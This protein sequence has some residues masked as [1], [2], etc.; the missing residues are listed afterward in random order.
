M[1][2]T[3]NDFVRTVTMSHQLT[4]E[5]AKLLD[6]G[7]SP[8]DLRGT[9]WAQLCPL[10]E[11]YRFT[12]LRFEFVPS[13]PSVVGGQAISY[14]EL[15][16]NEEFGAGA[17]LDTMIRVGNAHYGAKLHN[18]YDNV[19]LAIPTQT[20]LTDFFCQSDPDANKRLTQQARFR[21]V[22]TSGI[23]GLVDNS[24]TSIMIGSLRMIW[25]CRFKNPQIQSEPPPLL[26][27][28]NYTKEIASVTQLHKLFSLPRKLKGATSEPTTLQM[29]DDFRFI[30]ING[31]QEEGLLI[32]YSGATSLTVVA[33]GEWT[34]VQLKG[35][36]RFAGWLSVESPNVRRRCFHSVREPIRPL[37][38][39][40]DNEYDLWECYVD[41]ST[42]DGT[43]TKTMFHIFNGQTTAEMYLGYYSEPFHGVVSTT[44]ATWSNNSNA[45]PL[46]HGIPKITWNKQAVDEPMT[47]T[48][49]DTGTG[50]VR[51]FTTE[52]VGV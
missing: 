30:N 29:L 1:V 6:I 15:D 13:I 28:D 47:I 5:T 42:P 4:V 31:E 44:G 52:P 45:S 36:T 51:T 23:S 14:W 39:F 16:P 37:E 2:I 21:M 43:T 34:L 26:G 17:D 27:A 19:Q 32:P 10:F 48:K 3:G 40:V 25:T 18:I 8:I 7:L 20:G 22:A 24:T 35:V 46:A 33:P 49:I 9:R 50:V 41:I 38:S 12:S 11:K